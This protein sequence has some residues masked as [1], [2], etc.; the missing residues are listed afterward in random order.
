MRIRLFYHSVQSDWNNGNAHFLR[1][2][3]TEL[4]ARDHDVV[5]LEPRDNWSTRNLL[6]DGG[7][8]ALDA[9]ARQYP[10][11]RVEQYD[12]RTDL[13]RL[14]EGADLVVAHEWSDPA[15]LR[16]LGTLRR[17]S[18]F[19]LFYHDTHHRLITDRANVAAANLRDFDAVLAYGEVLAEAY[20]RLGL[21]ERAWTWHEAAD[22][23]VFT[24]RAAEACDG[25]LVWIGN[26]G[27]DER[28]A[29]LH[30][31]LIDPVRRLGLRATVYGVRYPDRALR[32]LA[33][34]GIGYGGWLP[35][36]EAPRVFARHRVTVHVPRGPYVRQLPGI[37]TIRPFEA[38]A[39][40]IALVSA[41]WRDAEGLFRPGADF[42][43]A[44]DGQAMERKLD[45]LLSDDTARAA[46]AARG[47]ETIRARHTCAHRV[48]ELLQFHAW[49]KGEAGGEL[50][51][52][53]A[54]A[55]SDPIVTT[56]EAP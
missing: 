25:D 43:I 47:L 11:L 15:L 27:D 1:G 54:V 41:P 9:F 56:T 23:R 45:A 26:W 55:E 16:G 44:T 18:D 51:P 5:V 21:T 7:A 28:E 14:V 34:A 36:F 4:A 50:S 37:P 31:F 6:A 33:G 20:R 3:A 53:A 2:F 38:L 19:V 13:A 29:E 10:L 48:D 17:S 49:A 24:P 32:A 39:C 8:P 22:T 35:N 46:Q 30:E 40:G 42:Q 52:V 12:D